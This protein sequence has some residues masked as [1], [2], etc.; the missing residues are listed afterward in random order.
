MRIVF[1]SDTHKFH[2]QLILP[3]GDM[4]VHCGD[5]SF[6]GKPAETFEFCKWFASQD[7]EHKVLISGNHDFNE[8]LIYV[9]LTEHKFTYLLHE[10]I[11][12]GGIVIFG[13]PYTPPFY[14]WNFMLN[15]DQLARRYD[16]IPQDTQL[17][18]THGPPNGIL[19]QT[20]Y[21]EHCGSVALLDR[22]KCL[23]NLRVHAFGHIHESAGSKV[24]DNVTF[25]NACSVDSRYKIVHPPIVYDWE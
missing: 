8:H 22:I 4:L 11:L 23:P 5:Y 14:D 9:A 3:E 24:L 2:D 21:D 1:I 19:D 20:H 7:F 18:I 6:T 15:E 12:L 25:I 13:S 16:E 10:P 17:L